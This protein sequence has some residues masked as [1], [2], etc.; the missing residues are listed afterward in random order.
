MS[1]KRHI[2]YLVVKEALCVVGF[3][4]IDILKTLKRKSRKYKSYKITKPH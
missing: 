3:I 4:N 2:K 1:I